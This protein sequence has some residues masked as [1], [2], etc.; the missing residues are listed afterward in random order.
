MAVDTAPSP[1][2]LRDERVAHLGFLTQLLK[3]PEIGSLFGVLAVFFL[4]TAAGNGFSE[5]G[6]GSLAGT[7]SWTDDASLIGIMAVPVALLMI[8]G[9]F[10]LSA[11]VMIGS[12]GILFALL[13]VNHHWNVWPAFVVV[14]LFGLAVGF[15]NGMLV[16][17]TKLPSFIVT[18]ATFFV[19]QGLN[20]GGLFSLT[21][22]V[23]ISGVDEASGYSGARKFFASTVWSPYDFQIR[24]FWCLAIAAIAQWILVRTRAGN[25]IFSVGGDATAARNVGVPVLQTKVA[26]FMTVSTM[27]ALSGVMR[28]LQNRS[29]EG[30]AGIGL[31]FE[32]I[33]AAVVGGCLLTGGYGSAVGALLGAIIMGMTTPG[34]VF[35]GWN[36][37]YHFLFLGVILLLAVLLN[38]WIRSRAE[39]ARG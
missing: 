38:T 14:M 33:I 37:D 22:K 27:A 34:I 7:S 35:A 32:F 16:M 29:I 13:T 4:F 24:V 20:L 6:F 8:A 31:E 10:D 15:V 39:A 36:S 28:T 30:A 25:W 3:R 17:K 1:K 18:L 12:S 23:Q 5:T 21:G 9:E 26:L 19:L 11:G 2:E